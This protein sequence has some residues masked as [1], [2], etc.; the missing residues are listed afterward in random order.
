MITSG[1]LVL[2]LVDHVQKFILIEARNM[3]VEVLTVSQD[4]TV[5]DMLNSGTM[6]SHNSP[7]M[8][9]VITQI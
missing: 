9:M 4:A 8:K 1:K 2:V 7:E 3:A 5:T 6:C